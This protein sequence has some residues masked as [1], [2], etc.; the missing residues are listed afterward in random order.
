[1]IKLLRK[2]FEKITTIQMWTDPYISLSML[3]YHLNLTNDIAS[4][5]GD[6]I[7]KTVN[8]ISKWLKKGDLICDFGCGPGLYTDLLQKEEFNVIGVDVS[9]NALDYAKSKNKNVRYIQQNY[10][11]NAIDES[12]NVAI[13][14]YCDFGAMSLKNQLKF[15]KNLTLTIKKGGYFI[16]DVCSINS[17]EQFIENEIHHSE[18][19]GFFMSGKT[20]ITS[21][22]KKYDKEHITL[23]YDLAIGHKTVEL[24]NWDKYYSINEIEKLMCKFNFKVIDVYSDTIG[25]KEFN[26]NSIYM[27]V[28]CK[29]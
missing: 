2:P 21:I 28:C 17:Y 3:K 25:N 18:V 23:K 6:T 1:M 19:D 29:L 27:F 14:I 20:D 11:E 12:I 9:I 5:N 8:F 10:I 26:Q 4:R 24:F 16:F 22:S 7:I 13:M 15:M